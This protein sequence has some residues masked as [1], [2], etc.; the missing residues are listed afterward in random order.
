M[1]LEIDATQKQERLI[2]EMLEAMGIVFNQ[3]S[4]IVTESGFE[5]GEN[6][7]QLGKVLRD[8]LGMWKDHDF[9]DFASFRKV[10]WGGRGVK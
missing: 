7:E 6:T 5:S 3:P 9:T 1:I 10:A 8:C 2:K 4:D